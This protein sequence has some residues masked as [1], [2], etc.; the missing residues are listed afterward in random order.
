MGSATR[1]THLKTTVKI[2]HF[3]GVLPLRNSNALLHLLRFRLDILSECNET[4]NSGLKCT[5][6]RLRIES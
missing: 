2:R 3:F 4:V 5:N 1:R 6:E